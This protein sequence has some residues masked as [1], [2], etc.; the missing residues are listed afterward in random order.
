MLQATSF[1]S[2]PLPIYQERRLRKPD[3]HGSI[4]ILDSTSSTFHDDSRNFKHLVLEKGEL[5]KQSYVRLNHTYEVPVDMLT[6]FQKGRCRAYKLRLSP[7]S[8]NMLI[9]EFG[10]MP[11]TYEETNTLFETEARRLAAL[12][13]FG[14][15]TQ[16]TTL[17]RFNI[18]DT[19]R[20][21]FPQPIQ[22]PIHQV[23]SVHTWQ[24]TPSAVQY[25]S[26]SFTQSQRHLPGPYS[27]RLPYFNP[28]EPS[29]VESGSSVLRW[30]IGIVVVGSLAWWRYS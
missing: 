14:R 7:E 17:P 8:Y 19:P 13:N 24:Q 30:I 1:G 10:L 5:R 6:Q 16:L 28:P 29:D 11:Q 15:L 12:A 25:G 4:P 22:F 9:G 23:N 2:T 3:Y 20:V 26:T 27:N 21:V 18:R